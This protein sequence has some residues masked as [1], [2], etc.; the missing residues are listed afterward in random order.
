MEN[1]IGLKE[2]RE[3]MEVWINQIQKGK[4]FMVVRKSKPIFRIIPP[5]TEEQW[6]TI[7]DFTTINKNG[8]SANKILKEL[9]KLNAQS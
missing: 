9:R 6:E 7:V 4:S 5:E 8:L 2:L 1:T 3:K